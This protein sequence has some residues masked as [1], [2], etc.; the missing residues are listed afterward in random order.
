MYMNPQFVN[1][2]LDK[3][4]EFR[5]EQAKRFLEIGVDVI[6]LADDIGVQK[7]MMIPPELWRKYLKPRMQRLIHEVKAKGSVKV[8]YHSDGYIEPVIPDLIEIG[9]DVLN[10]IQPECM[11]PAEIKKKY[12]NKLTLHGT[13]SVQETLSRGSLEDVRNE[14]L[15]RIRTCSEGGGFVLSP[16]NRITPDI[17]LEKVLA[18][19]ETAKKHG[20]Y[21]GS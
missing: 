13:I 6:C 4:L 9:V 15:E 14:V 12:G 7:G 1:T 17:S 21:M 3:I 2:L 18:V 19:Y 20:G 8:F 11:S 10:P 16:S 5:I